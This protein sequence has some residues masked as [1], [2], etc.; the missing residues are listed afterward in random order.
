MKI[1]SVYSYIKLI[2]R[3]ISVLDIV[4]SGR[5]DLS[6]NE[7][8]K[9]FVDLILVEPDPE[10]VVR[11]KILDCTLSDGGFLHKLVF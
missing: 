10:E 4:A 5:I 11:L 6:F 1:N 2:S 8:N 3:S 9:D 7:L